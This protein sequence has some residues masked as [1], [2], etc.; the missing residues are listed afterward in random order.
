MAAP[1]W[2][3]SSGPFDS[4]SR[5][6]AQ[7]RVHD[8]FES[9]DMNTPVPIPSAYSDGGRN[10]VNVGQTLPAQMDRIDL[11]D[12]LAFF[13]RRLGLIA[14][15]I[16]VALIIGA[17]LSLSQPK[18]FTAEALVSLQAPR[19]NDAANG[20]PSDSGPIASSAYVDTQ[21]EI[22]TSR[23]MATRVADA[24]GLRDSTDP[25]VEREA[26]DELQSNVSAE[27]SGESF[28]LSIGFESATADGAAQ[29]VNEFSRQ[30]TNWELNAS[31]ERTQDSIGTVKSRL[32]ELRVQAQS[33][34]AALQQ[35][36]IAN[37]L[38]SSSGA[39]LTEQEISVYNQR[40]SE[41]RAE[42]AEDQARLNTAL[43][44]LRSGSSGDDV[45]EALGSPVISS[46]RGQEALAAGE[47]ASLS[48]RY[49]P[50]YPQLIQ[51]RSE[52]SDVRQQIASEIGRVISNLKAQQAVSQ[53]RLS[54][55]TQSLGQA[56]AKLS[57]NNSAMVGLTE[58]ERNAEVSQGLY[59]TYL[60]NYQ[61]L[62]ASD[63]TERPNARIL[64]LAEAPYLPSSPNI[65]MNMVLALIIGMGAGL[66]V[67]Y[68]L[69]SLSN[70]ITGSDQIERRLGQRYL[71][72]MPLLK[73]VSKDEKNPVT[74]IGNAPKS[75]FAEAFRSLRTSIDQA[76]N[77]RIKTL[78]ITSALPDEGK[79]TTAVC[80]AQIMAMSGER[81][82]LIDFDEVKRGV[83]ELLDLPRERPGLT[84]LLNREKTLDEVLLQASPFLSILPIR[85][86]DD[87]TGNLEAD[88]EIDLLLTQLRR[89]FQRIVI[90]LPPVLPIAAARRLAEK[91]DATVMVVRWRKTSI[92]A[93]ESALHAMPASRINLLGVAVSQVDVRRRSQFNRTDPSFYYDQYSEYHA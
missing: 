34:T 82:L 53:Q 35:Y 20:L 6:D 26:I 42:A 67:A 44:Q 25:Q 72:A 19:E 88:A 46:L 14:A 21:V 31:K 68:I 64:S 83:S 52:L 75:V 39:S 7:L 51:K 33:D 17:A 8:I 23:E 57:Q 70:V 1:P 38:L 71:G 87:P 16:A 4:G 9:T 92:G 43:S 73:T 37:N 89:Q 41:A 81:T 15:I 85:P 47:V 61:N 65:P 55:L 62:V 59:E 5:N 58:L 60:N 66:L 80:L 13:R 18:T 50:N 28:A 84:E 45:G 86:T 49:G 93:I 11:T 69:E 48:S 22:I 90:D 32:D 78:A 10:L 36:R 63:G 3:G 12:S 91:A 24:L 74:A 56:S 76:G 27:R 54:S 79:T 77:G 2:S 40:V 29:T 30:F